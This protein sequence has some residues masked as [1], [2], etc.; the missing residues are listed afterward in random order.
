MIQIPIYR[1]PQNLFIIRIFR[2]IFGDKLFF[3]Y[4]VKLLSLAN[5][6]SFSQILKR[7]CVLESPAYMEGEC[8]VKHAYEC[9][10]GCNA[11]LY[12]SLSQR[13]CG[14]AR[15]GRRPPRRPRIK[16]G[17]QRARS[18]SF[19]VWGRT[20]IANF[21]IMICH[22]FCPWAF[23]QFTLWPEISARVH[24]HAYIYFYT[25]EHGQPTLAL[26][27]QYMAR[28][29]DFFDGPV[30]HHYTGCPIKNGQPWRGTFQSQGQFPLRG[31][32]KLPPGVVIDT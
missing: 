3:K 26:A 7:K 6:Y 27:Y 31:L 13:C 25:Y 15:G 30:D 4:P 24:T 28:F 8:V 5:F 12:L 9:G 16:I 20:P 1:F 14:V 19:G 10:I 29:T 2:N 22:E 32:N 18:A 21:G 17:A 11:V 23:T